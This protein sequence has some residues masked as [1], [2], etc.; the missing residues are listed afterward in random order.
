MIVVVFGIT[1]GGVVCLCA[2]VIGVSVEAVIVITD[3]RANDT[4]FDVTDRNLNDIAGSVL[5]N[6]VIGIVYYVID[7]VKRAV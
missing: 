3:D 2:V 5:V 1:D 4:V 6:K 7:G